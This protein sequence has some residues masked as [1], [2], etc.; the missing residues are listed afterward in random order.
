MPHDSAA[1]GTRRLIADRTD[2]KMG[3]L[4]LEDGGDRAV[5]NMVQPA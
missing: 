3:E 4:T 2:G 5:F 1:R